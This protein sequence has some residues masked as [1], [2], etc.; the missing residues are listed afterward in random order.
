[1]FIVFGSKVK[2]VK[3]MN[4]DYYSYMSKLFGKW[5]YF[6]DLVSIFISASG[7]RDRVVDLVDAKRNSRIL[8]LCTGTGDQAFAFGKR[9]YRVIGVDLSEKMLRLAEKKNK[10]ENVRFVVADAVNLPFKDDCFDVSCISFALHDMPQDIRDV[11]LTEIRRVSKRVVV[12]DYNIP[13]SGLHRWLHVSV[14]SL[15]ESKYYHDFVKRDLI[16]ILRLHSL[17]V[18][19]EAYGLVDFIKILICEKV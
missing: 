4:D 17:R 5:A 2:K 10:Y 16:E 15:Y 1:M 8:D 7:T 18:V 6:Y 13:K 19:E 3:K 11:V 9:G 14:A 12:V